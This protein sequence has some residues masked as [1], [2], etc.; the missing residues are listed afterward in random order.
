ML[1]KNKYIKERILKYT[2]VA[3]IALHYIIKKIEDK[4]IFLS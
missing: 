2:K 3:K 4:N 1:D